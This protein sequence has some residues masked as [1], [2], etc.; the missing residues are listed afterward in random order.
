MREQTTLPHNNVYIGRLWNPATQKGNFDNS[1]ATIDTIVLHSMDGTLQ[2]STAH[3]QNP[4]TI[5]S[6][7]YGIDFGGSIT[8]WLP[9]NVTAYH[10]G[11]YS[12]NQRSIGV[13]HEDMANNQIVR[14][15]TLYETSAK[16]I[17]EISAFYNIP[18]D[19]E[20]IKKHNEISATACPGSLDIDRIINRAKVLLALPQEEQL[21]D[22]QL[23]PSVFTNMVTKS[24]EYDELWKTLL[25][26]PSLKG[27]PGSHKLILDLFTAKLTEARN[28]QPQ[29]PVVSPALP[30]TPTVPTTEVP[31][32]QPVSIWRTDVIQ[33]L[34]DI[35]ASLRGARAN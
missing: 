1:R 3:F 25:L 28:A 8:Q 12:W 22:Y 31:P 33:T 27:N 32:S 35:L 19:R 23:K 24:S 2:G 15:D 29:I 17:A 4:D 11:E 7:H 14:P 6:A 30:V 16:L 20:H 18:L 13:E 10:A 9:E 26:D 5:P 34:K 21:H